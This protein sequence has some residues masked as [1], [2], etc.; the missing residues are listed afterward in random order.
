MLL[1][2]QAIILVGF[3][4]IFLFACVFANIMFCVHGFL[5]YIHSYAKHLMLFSTF[6]IK[7]EHVCMLLDST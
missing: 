1:S 2:M 4:W 3:V 5:T 6:S 7:Q